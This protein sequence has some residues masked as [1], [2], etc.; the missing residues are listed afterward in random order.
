MAHRNS[1][2]RAYTPMEPP[3]IPMSQIDSRPN[4]S[5]TWSYNSRYTERDLERQDYGDEVLPLTYQPRPQVQNDY[6]NPYHSPFEGLTGVWGYANQTR[7]LTYQLFQ[8][9]FLRPSK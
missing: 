5:S 4:T 3:A 9:Q 6:R 1:P 2:Y 8:W 7:D